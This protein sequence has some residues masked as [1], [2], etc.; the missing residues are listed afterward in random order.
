MCWNLNWRLNEDYFWGGFRQLRHVSW[1]D[2]WAAYDTNHSSVDWCDIVISQDYSYDLRHHLRPFP[3]SHAD[4]M[5]NRYFFSRSAFIYSHINVYVRFI[6]HS[7]CIN[8]AL[9]NLAMAASAF[10]FGGCIALA[11]LFLPYRPVLES[12]E[13]LESRTASNCRF[14]LSCRCNWGFPS[15]K[16]H[17]K[18]RNAFLNLSLYEMKVERWKQLLA[19]IFIRKQIPT[20]D[21]GKV[22]FILTW[23]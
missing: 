15:E 8:K 3:I 12:L 7:E 6:I 20:D 17:W 23:L 4:D 13:S 1:S 18:G 16:S 22:H 19:A 11:I 21:C 14:F 9:C 2:C 10:A 5:Y